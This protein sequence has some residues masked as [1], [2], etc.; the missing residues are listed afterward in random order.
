MHAEDID[1]SRTTGRG[2]AVFREYLKFA[3]LGAQVDA[4]ST[5]AASDH[6]VNVLQRELTERGYTVHTHVGI[7]GIFVDLAI[8]DPEDETRY[9]IGI[10]VDGESYRTSRSARDRDRTRGG[11]LGGQGWNMHRV[12]ALEWFRRPTEQLN[13]LIEAIEAAKHGRLK[14]AG[15]QLASSVST[16]E[17]QIGGPDPL[18]TA[19]ADAEPVPDRP[20]EPNDSR[21]GDD[22]FSM[23]DVLGTA[24]KV[25]GA[26]MTAKEGKG[27]DAAIRVLV[28]KDGKR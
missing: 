5:S 15:P 23:S 27:L 7:A 25:G 18:S 17:R 20:D 14:P 10:D 9:L 4:A 8:V 1:T 13:E 6:F 3:Q 16:I 19:V 11:V 26:V 28:G 24:I 21:G 22:G 2:P 12:W